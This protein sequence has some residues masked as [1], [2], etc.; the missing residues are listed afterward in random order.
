MRRL[1]TSSV[2]ARRVAHHEVREHFHDGYLAIAA[3]VR[4]GGSKG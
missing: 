4:E 3:D 1:G 2:S